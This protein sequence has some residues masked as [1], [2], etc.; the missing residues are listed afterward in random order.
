M[1]EFKLDDT[2]IFLLEDLLK[3]AKGEPT[4]ISKEDILLEAQSILDVAYG[5]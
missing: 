3:I 4:F 2:I 5:E 1:T